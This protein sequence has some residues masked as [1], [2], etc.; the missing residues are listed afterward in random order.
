MAVDFGTLDFYGHVSAKEMKESIRIIAYNTIRGLLDSMVNDNH[1]LVE[2]ID[3]V[4]ALAEEMCEEIDEEVAYKN[5]EMKRI[6][7]DWEAKQA[8][9]GHKDDNGGEG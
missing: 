9:E 3:G 2:R 7:M 8:T 6:T 4:I 1:A 5:S